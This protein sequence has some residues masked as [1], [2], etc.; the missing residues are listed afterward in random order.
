MSADKIRVLVLGDSDVGKTSLIHVMCHNEALRHAAST[1]I[2]AGI[3]V[4]W[5][6]FEEG[7]PNQKSCFIELWEMGGSR[8]HFMARPAFY[9]TVH[10]IVLVHD[11]TNSKSHSNLRKW[12]SEVFCQRDLIREPGGSGFTSFGSYFSG[13]VS[14]FLGAP[15]AF[16]DHDFDPEAFAAKGIP[17]LVVGTKA[18]L[19]PA[20]HSGRVS[21][22]AQQCC[23]DEILVDNT[24]VRS[25][26]AASTNAVKLSRFLD[27]VI[28]RKYNAFRV[29]AFA[30][31]AYSTSRNRNETTLF[32]PSKLS[33]L[34]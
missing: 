31:S 25:L 3:D 26:A 21:T 1:T 14:S 23:A 13:F 19:V 27:K 11:L 33:H 28:E 20:S 9:Q 4:R 10:G 32:M 30:Q 18:D 6:E 15:P 2:G 5:H 8:G 29:P 7:T 17:V 12:L 34:D 22:I 16:H 24:Q